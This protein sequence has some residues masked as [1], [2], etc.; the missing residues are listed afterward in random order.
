MNNGSEHELNDRLLERLVDGELSGAEYRTLLT[1]L[2]QY[3]DGWRRC[4]M[5]FLEDQA[6]GREVRSARRQLDEPVVR[7]RV[8]PSLKTWKLGGMLTLASAA[9]F[10]LAYLL[11]ASFIQSRYTRLGPNSNLVTSNLVDRTGGTTA[12]R[13]GEGS[14]S[15]ELDLP[16]SDLPLGEYV[17]NEGPNQIAMPIFAAEDPRG[18]LLLNER[19]SMPV[20]VMRG[21]QRSGYQVDRQRQWAVG[22]EADNSV[23]VPIEELQITPVSGR[24]Y[25]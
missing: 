4:A 7:P 20:E 10:L 19:A 21:L 11:A 8:P 1:E 17:V 13:P 22:G 25:Q 14:A 2:D 5:A 9:S 15:N 24:A 3:P 16:N 6:W 12:D 18:R 23:L